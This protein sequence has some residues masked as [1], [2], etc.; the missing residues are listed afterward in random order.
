MIYVVFG[1]YD[2]RL[3]FVIRLP[4]VK[5]KMSSEISLHALIKYIHCKNPTYLRIVTLGLSGRRAVVLLLLCVMLEYV[6]HVS[7]IF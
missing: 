2:G 4:K 6:G 3:S 1:T 7:L 5:L